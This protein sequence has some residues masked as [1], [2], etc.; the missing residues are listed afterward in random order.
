MRKCSVCGY[1]APVCDVCSHIIEVEREL[2]CVSD[3]LIQ[4]QSD[5]LYVFH[6]HK[7]CFRGCDGRV[8]G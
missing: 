1:I 2:V 3:E 5:C 4:F 8:I 7:D 6:W